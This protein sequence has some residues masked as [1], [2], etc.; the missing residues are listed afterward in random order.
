MVNCAVIVSGSS[1]VTQKTFRTLP[2][3]TVEFSSTEPSDCEGENPSSAH[4]QMI[5][6]T[7][8]RL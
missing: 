7:C 6:I 5:I 8:I 1:Q 2:F 3:R 4:I